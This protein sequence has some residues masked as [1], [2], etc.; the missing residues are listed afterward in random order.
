M[1][2]QNDAVSNSR[3]DEV[4]DF[5]ENLIEGAGPK[6]AKQAAELLAEEIRNRITQ[7][8]GRWKALAAS[9]I[10]RKKYS[11]S[12][13]NA[14]KKWI[15]TGGFLRSI[16]AKQ[17]SNGAQVFFAGQKH[18]RRS[19]TSYMDVVLYNEAVRPLIG[20]AFKAVE[21]QMERIVNN[22]LDARR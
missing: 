21:K 3:I 11:S 8:R 15:E 22:V 5:F 7:Q 10:R 13:S 12:A 17:T 20:P 14:T 18:S 9:T 1:A 6:I 2:S 16:E 19:K 4:F